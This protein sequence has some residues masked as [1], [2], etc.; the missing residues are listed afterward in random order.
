[1]LMPA[2]LLDLDGTLS[3][4][5]WRSQILNLEL[6]SAFHRSAARTPSTAD[7]LQWDLFFRMAIHDQPIS[8]ICDFA[9]FL[10]GAGHRS[11]VLTGRPEWTRNLSI[12]WLKRHGIPFHELHMRADDDRSSNAECKRRLLSDHVL[13]RYDVS[14]AIDDEHELHPILAELG[15][16]SHMASDPGLRPVG[17]PRLPRRFQFAGP[18]PAP[19]PFDGDRPKPL[20]ALA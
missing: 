1:M 9:R 12:G 10:V 3:S 18:G 16:R 5:G 8:G 13:G 14:L 11:I 15:L 4:S 19:T 20:V 7:D 6:P 2:V 17:T